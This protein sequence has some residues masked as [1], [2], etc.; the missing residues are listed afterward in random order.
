[1]SDGMNR[2]PE[3]I[4]LTQL[5]RQLAELGLSVGLV[6]ARPAAMIRAPGKNPPLWITV[7][8]SAE[9]FEWSGTEHQHPATDLP[10]A[11]AAISE[12]VKALLSGPDE[13]S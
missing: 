12:H 6:D 1:M 10:G 3:L 11:A 5:C 7:D 13:A 4:L 2:D 9:F 8:D